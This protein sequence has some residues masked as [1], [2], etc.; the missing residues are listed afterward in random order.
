MNVTE[1]ARRL[2]VNTKE[3]LQT[4]PDYG[5]D[6]GMKSIKIDDRVAQQVMRKWKYIRRDL[7]DKKRKEL[8]EKKLKEKELRKE[9]GKTVNLPSLVTVR[10]F[11]ERLELPVTQVLTELM[12]NGIQAN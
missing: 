11:A 2:R 3:L 7:E 10:N 5:F 6:V 12:K 8:E 4:L 1:L 9:M